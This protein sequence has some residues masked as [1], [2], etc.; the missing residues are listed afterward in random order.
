LSHALRTWRAPG[1]PASLRARVM[2]ERRRWWQ[3]LLTG[4]IRIPAPAAIAALVLLTAWL[5]ARTP[6]APTIPPPRSQAPVTLADFTPV[7][8]LVP[9][10][11]GE[12]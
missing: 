2:G 3:W 9:R 10:I 11:V 12:Q 1:A 6:A 5:Y 8:A 7:P 4:S